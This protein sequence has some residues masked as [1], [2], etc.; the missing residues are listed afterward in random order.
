MHLEYKIG[1]K[2]H[3][4]PLAER[5]TDMIGKPVSVHFIGSG[6]AE[7]VCKVL[8]DRGR[9]LLQQALLKLADE[10]DDHERE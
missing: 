7:I 9:G 10:P 2:S 4:R 8:K 1:N 5:L 3:A 6:R